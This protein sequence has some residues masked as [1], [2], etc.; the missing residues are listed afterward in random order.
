MKHIADALTQLFIH[1]SVFS[2]AVEIL[3]ASRFYGPQT[4]DNTNWDGQIGTRENASVGERERL[5]IF[6]VLPQ[7]L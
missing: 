4:N 5:C 2:V 1:S 3:Y 6:T 7:L